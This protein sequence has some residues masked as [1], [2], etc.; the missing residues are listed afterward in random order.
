[1]NVFDR[2]KKLCD[3]KGISISQL[4]E[5]IEIS[6]GAAYKWKTSSPSQKMF[7]KLST[8][9]DV[10]IDYLMTG[11]EA[12]QKEF[13]KTEWSE[14]KLELLELFDGLKKEQKSA[15][16]NLLRSFAL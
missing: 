4:E 15:V 11:K 3:L 9:F 2:I 8:F 12:E 14:E 16:M 13:P 1:M 10:S 6:S 7:Q 5:K